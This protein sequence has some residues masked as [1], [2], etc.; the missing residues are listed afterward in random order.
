MVDPPPP[1]PRPPSPPLPCLGGCPRG[2]PRTPPSLPRWVAGWRPCPL[3]AAAAC[4][5]CD[6]RG[7]AW[8]RRTSPRVLPTR[9]PWGRGPRGPW[10]APGPHCGREGVLGLQG[11]ALGQWPT[12]AHA[13]WCPMVAPWVHGRGW[14]FLLP[15]VAAPMDQVQ[16]GRGRLPLPPPLAAWSS[17]PRPGVLLAGPTPSPCMGPGWVRAVA[18][19]SQRPCSGWCPRPLL[20]FCR[21]WT[22]CWDSPA[23]PC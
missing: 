15:V 14:W 19:R 10:G 21:T 4:P 7:S 6:R 17:V 23:S 1:P 16:V 11:Q 18:R 8:T 3:G 13:A 9:C 2:Q 22:R 5:S 12:A 20:W